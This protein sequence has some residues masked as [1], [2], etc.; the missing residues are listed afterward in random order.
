M[1]KSFVF[2]VF[3]AVLQ[4]RK[5]SFQRFCP[6]DFSFLF[7]RITNPFKENLRRIKKSIF[8]FV[9]KKTNLVCSWFVSLKRGFSKP[10]RYVPAS[11]RT[12][13]AKNFNT[14]AVKSFP[15]MG[16]FFPQPCFCEQQKFDHKINYQAG[17]SSLK[18]IFQ[19]PRAKCIGREK[20]QKKT[21]K[22]HCLEEG[23]LS[24]FGLRLPKTTI[25][26]YG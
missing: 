5:S 25:N 15:Q 13:R 20:K 23:T 11:Q 19:T 2:Q 21:A 26:S 12:S 3:Q 16:P 14:A 1:H 18:K 7:K 8:W 6:E 17:K 9:F 4:K 24:C 10:A 22:A